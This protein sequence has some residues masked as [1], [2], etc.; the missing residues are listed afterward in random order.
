MSE[1]PKVRRSKESK[2]SDVSKTAAAP[3]FPPASCTAGARI[4][5]LLDDHRQRVHLALVRAHQNLEFSPADELAEEPGAR[6]LLSAGQPPLHGG[7][8]AVR[9]AEHASRPGARVQLA[10]LAQRT[11]VALY[12][13]D[14]R[15]ADLQRDRQHL[16]LAR[17]VPEDHAPG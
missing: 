15:A 5:R 11:A 4:A 16:F 17:G 3:G 10:V 8:F 12:R 13:D 7:G 14:G 6:R 1:G 9:R 2:E